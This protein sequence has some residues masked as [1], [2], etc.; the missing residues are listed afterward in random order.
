MKT[1]IV[2]S[3]L[4]ALL[5]GAASGGWYA[6]KESEE[7]FAYLRMEQLYKESALEI[8]TYAKLLRLA[9]TGEEERVLKYLE[10]LL[11]SAETTLVAT[12]NDVPEEVQLT[13]G[14]EAI[15]YLSQYRAD[16]PAEVEVA[17]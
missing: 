6:R 4:I 1:S 8:K 10:A 11:G 3:I 17:P 12:R 5:V 16:F 14:D 13:V 7:E 2:L 15:D 9:R